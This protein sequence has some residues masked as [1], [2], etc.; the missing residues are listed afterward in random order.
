M[1]SLNLIVTLS[2]PYSSMECFYCSDLVKISSDMKEHHLKFHSHLPPKF[3]EIESSEST[4]Q[5]QQ[6][7][8]GHCCSYIHLYSGL[9]S[10]NVFFPSSYFKN[11]NKN[12]TTVLVL[13]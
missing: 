1:H 7:E 4:E 9:E 13:F 8:V 6:T 2:C 12:Q 10:V 11:T 5:L 3:I